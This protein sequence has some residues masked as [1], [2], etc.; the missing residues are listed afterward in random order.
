LLTSAKFPLGY[1]YENSAVKHLWR[2]I[3]TYDKKGIKEREEYPQNK[4]V[5]NKETVENLRALIWSLS[6][7][8]KNKIDMIWET[9]I[10]SY[11]KDHYFLGG[12]D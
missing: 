9:Q 10:F 7:I 12:Y 11:K 8:C 4:K 1:L 2:L 3:F 5:E 6:L